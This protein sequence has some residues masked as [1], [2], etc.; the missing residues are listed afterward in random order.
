[1]LVDLIQRCWNSE[2]NNRPTS[3]EISGIINSWGDNRYSSFVL[4]KDTIFYQ[5]I[6]EAKKHNEILPKEI[7][8]PNYQTK[9]TVWHSKS[10]NT[11]Q[12]TELYQASKNVELNINDF[13]LD[14]LNIQNESEQIEQQLQSYQEIPPKK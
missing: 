11:K 2:P 8:Y 14:E 9:E 5:Q 12:I 1:M 10:I 4:K 7:R 13:N 6:Q 3:R